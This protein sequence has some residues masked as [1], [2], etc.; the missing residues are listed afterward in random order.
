M[1]ELHYAAQKV[2]LQLGICS[3]F[4]DPSCYHL[5]TATLPSHTLLCLMPFVMRQYQQS[6]VVI[7]SLDRAADTSLAAAVKRFFIRLC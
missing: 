3:T 4:P 2:S 6:R 5:A 7:D 1:T